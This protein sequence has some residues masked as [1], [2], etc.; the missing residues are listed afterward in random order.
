M[1]FGMLRVLNFQF[2]ACKGKRANQNDDQHAKI[3]ADLLKLYH[4]NT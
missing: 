4:L 2:K 3:H 1:C